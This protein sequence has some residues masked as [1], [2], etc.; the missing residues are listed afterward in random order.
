[1]TK[2]SRERITMN[3]KL[4]ENIFVWLCLARMV[5]GLG[6][7]QRQRADLEFCRLLFTRNAFVPALA[8]C[9]LIHLFFH[10]APKKAKKI[11]LNEFLGDS[12][13]SPDA[14]ALIHTHP[15]S[16]FASSRIMGRRDGV[17]PEC[18]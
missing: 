12:G 8:S 7:K 10:T 14:M 16:T 13:A 18:P 3:L 9:A 11:S 15:D 6:N 1:M 4:K 17:P 5:V 2:A